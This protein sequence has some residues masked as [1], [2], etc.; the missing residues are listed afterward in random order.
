[1]TDITGME[2]MVGLILIMVCRI[3]D[4]VRKLRK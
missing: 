2:I 4:D 3:A 1:M